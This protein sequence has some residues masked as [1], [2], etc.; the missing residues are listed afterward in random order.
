MP[1]GVSRFVFVPVGGGADIV[2]ARARL[3][4]QGNILGLKNSRP[5]RT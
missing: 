2:E 1:G 3:P 5:A 4:E